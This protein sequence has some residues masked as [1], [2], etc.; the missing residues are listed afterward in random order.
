[1]KLLFY[2]HRILKPCIYKF[3]IVKFYFISLHRLS[4]CY[5]NKKRE[6][7]SL[8]SKWAFKRGLLILLIPSAHR[9]EIINPM[10]YLSISSLAAR[11]SLQT[12]RNYVF[13]NFNVSLLYCR[14]GNSAK[15]L[16]TGWKTGVRFSAWT[17]FSL[18]QHLQVGSDARIASY[19]VH[20]GS[21]LGRLIGRSV[22]NGLERM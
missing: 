12:F 11:S 18:S 16:T 13:I 6:L 3:M 2:W 19:T 15:W 20:T 5:K 7:C 17:G 10:V 21:I 4:L 14:Q 22:N 1:M 8:V 9:T